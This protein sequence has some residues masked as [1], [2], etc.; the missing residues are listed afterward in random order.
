VDSNDTTPSSEGSQPNKN[1]PPDKS[2]SPSEIRKRLKLNKN[3]V[4]SVYIQM[5][6]DLYLAYHR[7]L[8]SK[9]GYDTF[10]DYVEQ[11]IGIAKTRAERLRRIW[12]KYV[13]KLKV[14]P[15]ELQ[16]LG[17]TNAFTMLSIVDSENVHSWIGRAKK[18]AWRDLDIAVQAA[19]GLSKE[20]ADKVRASSPA[21]GAIG[22][23]TDDDPPTE[24]GTES[25]PLLPGDRRRAWT[26]RLYESQFKVVDAA[27]AEAKRTKKDEMAEN[28][29]LAHVATEFLASRMSKEEKPLARLQF[30]LSV[31]EQVYGGKFVWIKNDDA[32]VFLG[33]AMESRPDL[34]DQPTE[35]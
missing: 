32:A 10:T 22:L 13:R 16:G 24:D 21:A 23:P 30:M 25:A 9:W 8:Y 1:E 26:F 5:G 11:E 7:R 19:K 18:M 3:K 2:D 34:F 20:D 33:E 27:V 14:S 35:E 31:F 6:R 29:A 4:D 12:T 28:E 17:F 15:L